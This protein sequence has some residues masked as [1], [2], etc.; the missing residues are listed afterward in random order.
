MHIIYFILFFI[1]FYFLGRG[2]LIGINKLSKKNLFDDDSIF[3]DTSILIFYP[4]VGIIFFS[5]LM[6]VSNFFTS[7]KNPGLFLISSLFILL[8]LYKRVEILKN[9]FIYLISLL[10]LSILSF[11]SYDINFQYDAGYYHLNYQ[12]WLREDKL[13]LGLNNLNAAFGT[14]SIIDYL[15]A[16]F[17]IGSNL[18]FLHYISIFF[19]VVLVNFLFYH[20]FISNNKYFH[21]SSV[22]LLFFGFLDNFGLSGGRNGFFTIHGIIKPDIA[23]GII[24]YLSCIFLTYI[25]INK[26]YNQ[27]EIVGLNLLI[28]FAYQLKIS[29]SLLFLF[30]L[31]I[32][33]NSKKFSFKTL[34]Y[35]NSLLILWLVKNIFL[36]SCLI[37]PIEVTCFQLPWY[38]IDAII[39]IANVTSDFNNSYIIGDSFISWFKAW[40]MI[41]INKTIIYNFLF[42]LVIVFIIKKFITKK[43]TENKLGDF[44]FPI[45]F[46]LGNLIIWIVGAAHPRF[47]YGLFAYILSMLAINYK[48]VEIRYSKSNFTNLIFL[49]IFMVTVL[50]IP[51]VNSYKTFLDDPFRNPEITPPVVEY[52][53]LR[54]NWVLPKEGDQCWINLDCIPYDKNI[55]QSDFLIYKGFV[56]NKPS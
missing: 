15:A 35:T 33:I 23:S 36:T 27:I 8:N 49:S 9:K 22:L 34:F 30:F 29:S 20:I 39:G 38:N 44:I 46:V 6:F 19:V 18:I 13:I 42:S 10:N 3:F 51:R 24:F 32:L 43:I 4:L 26:K 54:D 50:L 1:Y 28:I 55:F 11:S 16:P 17:W 31:M 48:A 56:I 21:L 40:I 52:R 37:Y 2:I 47:I 45:C 41:E 7:L 5:N 25:Y 53:D 14:S 12:N